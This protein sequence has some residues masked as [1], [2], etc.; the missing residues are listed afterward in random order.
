M[1]TSKK[2]RF[3]GN[4]RFKSYYVLVASLRK[5]LFSRKPT[6]KVIPKKDNERKNS[7]T[8]DILL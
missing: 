2:K 8:E 4:L 1:R 6:S 7:K 3:E 5:S